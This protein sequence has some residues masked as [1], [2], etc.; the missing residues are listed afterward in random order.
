MRIKFGKLPLVAILVLTLVVTF[1]PTSWS[2]ES[3]GAQVFA[4]GDGTAGNPYQIATKAQ[5][6]SVRNYPDK[7][8]ILMND[9]V[10]ASS[11]FKS[12]GAYYNSG[13]GWKPIGPLTSAFTGTFNGNGKKITGLVVAAAGG[14]NGGLFNYNNGTITNLGISGGT[15]SATGSVFS[16][17]GGI[18]AENG[19]TIQNCY[20]SATVSSTGTAGGVAGRSLNGTVAKCFN[21]GTV[22]GLTEVGGICGW[23]GEGTLSNCYNTGKITGNATSSGNHIGGIAGAGDACVLEHCYNIGPVTADFSV[24]GGI[25]AYRSS[26]TLTDCFYLEGSGENSEGVSLSSTQMEQ[27]ASYHGFDFTN[28]WV[29]NTY[30]HLPALRT[31]PAR[32]ASIPSVSL[33]LSTTYSDASLRYR[34]I[35][36]KWASVS[37]ASGYKVWYKKSTDTNAK[38]AYTTNTSWSMLV[39]AGSKYYVKVIPYVSVAGV[40]YFSKNYSPEKYTFTLKAPSLQLSKSGTQD[41]DVKWGNIVGESGY[42]IY[43]K[44]GATGSW[45]RVKIIVSSSAA[46]WMDSATVNGKTYYYKIKAYKTVGGS[47]V[48]GPLSP[49]ET[50]N[51]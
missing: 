19:G 1:Y 23:F 26:A 30:N 25:T 31:C 12:G 7:N 24:T 3:H 4:G 44:T 6:S 22:T 2:M 42:Y 17:A 15:I 47:A 13:S 46:S 18:A 27:S 38:S 45:T 28:V 16:H 5:L 20:S 14:G 50:I 48:Y 32:T 9:I 37:N 35:K 33:N 8:Y 34:V 40:K 36:A 29:W 11:D 10:F 39:D 43:R 49:E 21:A 51:R 41:V